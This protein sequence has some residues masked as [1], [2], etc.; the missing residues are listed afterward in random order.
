MFFVLLSSEFWITSLHAI[1]TILSVYANVFYTVEKDHFVFDSFLIKQEGLKHL[2]TGK[3]QV[4]TPNHSRVAVPKLS[5]LLMPINTRI[6]Q[7]AYHLLTILILI[8]KSWQYWRTA[9]LQ[10]ANG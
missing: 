3:I 2:V 1:L 7:S 8:S 9:I 4:Q 6:L 10:V 5:A